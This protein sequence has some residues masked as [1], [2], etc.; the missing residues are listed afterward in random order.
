M[1]IAAIL[2]L[3]AL[4]FGCGASAVE[5]RGIS[6]RSTCSSIVSS[7]QQMGARL[8]GQRQE[9]GAAGPV[10]VKDLAGEIGGVPVRIDV[11]CKGEKPYMIVFSAQVTS[12]VEASES[13]DR[14]RSSVAA[15]LGTAYDQD[16]S[17]GRRVGFGCK[18]SELS[19]ALVEDLVSKGA[20]SPSAA[21]LVV[22][23]PGA[24]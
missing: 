1:R 21:L 24:C 18:P 8:I 11:A 16:G 19:V 2:T 17:H 7:E 4:C 23:E 20:K 5:F 14:L 15:Q 10:Q 6:S 13:F 9:T 22:P 3:T 12:D